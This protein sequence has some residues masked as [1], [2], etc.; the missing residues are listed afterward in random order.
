MKKIVTLF[1]IFVVFLGFGQNDSIHKLEEIVLNGS[2]TPILNSGYH[3]EILHDSILENENQSLGNLLQNQVNLYFKQNGNGMVS[4]I[5]L[6]GS[7]ASQTGVYWNGIAINS[8]LNGQTDFNTLTANS[9][10]EIEIRKGGG[11]VLLGSGAIGG[12]IN[13]KD[14]IVFQ[15]KTEIGLNIGIG[16]YDTYS[17]QAK[18]MMSNKKLFAKLAM[19]G[20]TSANDY[21][22]LDSNLKNEN[23]AFKNYNINAVFGYNFDDKNKINANAVVYDNERNNSRTLTAESNAKLLNTDSRF[24]VD[25]KNFGNRYS[26]SVKLAYLKEDFTYFFDENTTN[27]SEGNSKNFIV[28]E[29]F[30]YFLN[31]DLFLSTGFEF[32][33]QNGAGTNIDNVEQN[34]FTAYLLVHHEP[35]RN[36][37]YN[38]SVRKGTSSAYKIPFIYAFDVKYDIYESVILKANYATNYRLPTFN[39]LYWEPGGNTD[40]NAEKSDS[41]EFGL[42]LLEKNFEINLTSFY[43]KSKDL[44]QWQPVDATIWQPINIQDVTNYG[45]EFSA[46]SEKRFDKHIFQIKVQYDYTISEDQSLNKQ[47]IYV[48]IHKA[49]GILNYQYKNWNVN[50]NLQ[51]TGEVFITTSNSQSLDAYWLSN[52]SVSKRIFKNKFK[53]SFLVNNLFNENYESVAYRPM[54]NRNFLINLNL[55][56]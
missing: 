19:G 28:K 47:M 32:K 56:L 7:N 50:Y 42:T 41:M 33:N 24:L 51:Y 38:A 21:P 26:S 23:G 20:T 44:I 16:S 52:L 14:K 48:P 36:F 45:V 5:A 11:S 9:F 55:K 8:S 17:G 1:S 27:S 12:A 39:D 43:I 54:P 2:F 34:D 25:W 4:S 37:S 49:N 10:D 35:L 13:L 31:Q 30:T 46:F 53:V 3:V 22:Y 40:L 6:R 29:D 15:E 18:V